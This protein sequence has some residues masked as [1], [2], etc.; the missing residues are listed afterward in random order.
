MKLASSRV[1]LYSWV[2]FASDSETVLLLHK[3]LQKSFLDSKTKY[4]G[5]LPVMN[6]GL[7]LETDYAQ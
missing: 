7:H 2:T 1:S 4:L 6:L 3:L 5:L